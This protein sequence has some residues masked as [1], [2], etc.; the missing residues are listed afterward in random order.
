MKNNYISQLHSISKR[1]STLFVLFFLVVGVESVS[2][3]TITIGSNTNWS[4]ITTG[5]G[6]GG[7]PSSSDIIII[8]NGKTL[9][10]NSAT[11]V[12][13]SIQIGSTATNSGNGTLVF[14]NGSQV[15][16]SGT[17]TLGMG[18]RIGTLTMTNGGILICNGLFINGSGTNIFNSGNGTVIL[19][20]TN[21]L[22]STTFTTFN[23]LICNAGSTTTSAGLTIGGNLYIGDGTTFNAAA[24]STLTVSGTTTVG[25]G[26]S[27]TFIISAYNSAPVLQGSITINTGGIWNNTANSPVNFQNGLTNY[28]TFIPG[29]QTQ[30][31]SSN[32]QSL[33]GTIDMTGT[34][35]TITGVTLTN[36]DMLTV[37]GNFGGTGTFVNS[38]T[39]TINTSSQITNSN[40]TNQGTA[41][42]SGGN[43]TPTTLT[44][45]S[46][47][48]LNISGVTYTNP[49]TF[50]N[51]GTLTYTSSKELN[52][53][54]TN[55]GTINV[56]SSGYIAGITNSVGGTLNISDL[57]YRINTLTATAAGN[58]VNYNGA[59]Q[60]VISTNYYY[61]T[62]SGAS[63]KTITS[64]F[65]IVGNLNIS[66]GTATL[67]S[68]V[69][70]STNSL[71]LGATNYA[72]GTY[73]ST[74]SA[75]TNKYDAYFVGSGIITVSNAACPYNSN[76]LTGSTITP[77]INMPS[78]VNTIS[79]SFRS[80]QYFVLNVI[81]GLTYQ[82]Y[83]NSSPSNA[84]ALKMVVYEE[85]NPSASVLAS[86]F[87]NTGNSVGNNNDVYLIFTAPLSGQ[88]RVLIN[89]R[90]DC[91]STSITGLTVNANVSGGSNTQDD[92]TS[93]GTDT[94]IGH[95]Y[96]GA[97]FNNYIGYYNVASLSGITD[98]FQESFG[99]GGTWPNNNS[100]DASGFNVSSNGVVRAQE[101]KQTFTAHYRMNSTKRG[102]YTVSI[103][104]DDG[105]RLMVDNTKVYDDWTT[106]APKVDNTQLISLSG[107]SSL[108]LDYYEANGQNVIGFYNLTQV[109]SNALTTNTS[110]TLCKSTAGV[111]ISGDVLGT[112][113]TG[114][115]LVGY[116]WYY[117]TTPTGTRTLISGATTATYT[118]ASS[119]A[120][121]NNTTGNYYLYRVTTLKSTLN[122]GI[123]SPTNMTNE[124][125]AVIIRVRSC[126][127]YWIGS[128]NITTGTSWQTAANWSDGIPSDGDNIAFAAT[129]N[130]G[131]NGQDAAS[132]LI[133]DN[134]Y[135]VGDMTNNSGKKLIIPVGTGLTVNGSIT[136]NDAVGDNIYIKSEPEKINGTLIFHN[137]STSSVKATVEMYSKATINTSGSIDNQY[138][139]QY[140]GVP[141]TSVIAEPTLY[142]AYVRRANEAGNT[143]DTTYYWIELTNSSELKPFIGH[144][145]CQPTTTTYIFKGQLVN[146][147]FD[148]GSLAYTVGA[149]YPG[150]HLFANPYTAAI[151]VDKIEF[152][153]DLD[154]TVFLYNTGSYGNWNTPGNQTSS[155][156]NPGQYL[157][158]PQNVAGSGGIPGEVP[159]M[160]S[161]LVKTGGNGTA[162][163]YLK[164]KYS[165]VA[166]KNTVQQRVKSVDAITNTD[167]ISTRI[168]LT[169][170]HY[171]D[172][173]WIFTEPS[174][175]RN[176]DNGWDGRKMLGSS[177]APQ[178]YAMEPDGDYQVNS[179]SDMNNTDLAFQAG[180]EVEYTLKFTH[181]NV[182]R[183]YAGVYLVDLVENKTVDVSQNGSTYTFAT[184]Q[185]DA[186]AKRFKIL[187]RSYEKG[188]PDK[189]AQV[190]IFAASG[191]V[192][193]QNLSTV[194]G[195][196]TLYDI[197]GR[198]IKKAPF[199]ANAVTEVLNNITPGAYVV[200]TITNGEK[201]SKRVIVQ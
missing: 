41:N 113:P 56:Q 171:S 107:S 116:Q 197:A 93:A 153:S 92:P 58:T 98:Q 57:S 47:G 25:G 145:I 120:P 38:A 140:F 147:D 194:K 124:S 103:A 126:P 193:V 59:A 172:R 44:N 164:F 85:G 152:G 178:I 70:I 122:V 94:W 22:P 79:T 125:N 169:G 80:H 182:Q 43:L 4:A 13:A 180:D 167:L 50:T 149:T 11:A 170:Q 19:N 35:I 5:S 78:N 76:T 129:T 105:V 146:T 157:S 141:L 49:T 117:S 118:P 101:L 73:G 114:I 8:N 130:T 160:S 158:I 74:T 60:T 15:T 181:E 30:T 40:F 109:F 46:T 64:S 131:N 128:T 143:D 95:V 175:T 189:E 39:G 37:T 72:I 71:T 179:V 151:N 100:D 62:L 132:D 55:T 144:E 20:A 200:N 102:F 69:N 10:V 82:I 133:L 99:T 63:T 192:F 110:Q 90:T 96:D 9:T 196:C 155:G 54:I 51:Q 36:T 97:S 168:D 24:N 134:Y 88:V 166:T 115:T 16:V 84:N 2:G 86:S 186:P 123:T 14:N 34:P 7:L 139:W 162:G 183:Q 201:V 21:T 185:S 26:T 142:G 89:S 154:K 75:A 163:S 112:L 77:V 91:S 18:N 184:A 104:S 190:K 29:T 32:A 81:K 17:V 33:T 42:V 23:N 138:F 83:T 159:S 45:T 67:N 176:F 48:I 1:L 191:R 121:F 31:F 68:G 61:L 174:C 106:H 135:T 199:A 173:M 188:A 137:P 12:C 53:P 108:L 87:S 6:I 52:T 3:V 66:T 111:A 28:G 27:G 119:S 150:Q 195:E 187:T 65:S 161:M 198:A 136:T 148:S 165:D 177:L 156:D 127:N